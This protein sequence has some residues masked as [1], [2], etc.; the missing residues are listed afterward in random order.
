MI[1]KTKSLTTLYESD[2]ALWL[3]HTAAKL[4][5]GN[6]QGLDIV[7]LLEEI[8]GLLGSQKHELE[9]RLDVII[10]HILKRCHVGLPDCYRGWEIT[11]RTQR[12]ELRR[13]LSKSPSL[14]NYFLSV[15]AEI[16][17][18][19]LTELREDYPQIEFPDTW[20]FS[21]DIEAILTDKFWV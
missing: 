6:L 5:S 19:T 13:L 7:S 17:Q 3:E 14:Q 4:R 10:S 18:E 12:K 21:L 1:L 20:Q 11:I 2:F 16:H 9:S 8:E 15:F